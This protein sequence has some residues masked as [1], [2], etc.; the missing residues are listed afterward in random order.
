LP[1]HRFVLERRVERSR[2]RLLEGRRSLTEIALEAGFSHP[3]HILRCM[4]R[5]SGARPSQIGTVVSMR[6]GDYKIEANHQMR[7]ERAETYT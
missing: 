2:T 5:V 4:R 1:V 3:S 7:V 6:R